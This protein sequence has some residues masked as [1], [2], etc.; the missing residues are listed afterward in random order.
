MART[1]EMRRP[2]AKDVCLV[3]SRPRR[4][5][6]S[7]AEHDRQEL[8]VNTMG[9]RSLMVAASLRP[10]AAE[11]TDATPRLSVAILRQGLLGLAAGLL[12]GCAS[13]P[14]PRYYAQPAAVTGYYPA[15]PAPPNYPPQVLA[16]GDYPPHPVPPDY[17]APPG[18]PDYPLPPAGPRGYYPPHPVPPDYVARPAPPPDYS[19]QV[20]ARHRYYP[21]RPIPPDYPGGPPPPTYPPPPGSFER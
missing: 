9:S 3:T 5:S 20:D 17:V 18:P 11:R 2:A 21:P 1:K 14:A 15:Q 8:E 16:R 19:P 13:G 10:P 4:R 12:V 7:S 6:I